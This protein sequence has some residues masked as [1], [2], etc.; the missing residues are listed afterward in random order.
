MN[1]AGLPGTGLGGL[2]YVVLALCMPV[3]EV[4]RLL[5][6]RS[7]PGRWRQ[8]VT[9]FAMACGVVAALAV[10]AWCYVQLVG[11]PRPFGLDGTA[12]LL[13]PVV[14]AVVLLVTLVVVLRVWAWCLRPTPGLADDGRS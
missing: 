14:L 10:T 11:A 5:R 8:V 3:V 7:Q 2:F 1:N 6:G 4:V 12:L 13:G 9:Q